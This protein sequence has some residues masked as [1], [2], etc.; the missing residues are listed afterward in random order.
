MQKFALLIFGLVAVS[1]TAQTA[2]PPTN[3]NPLDISQYKDIADGKA[4]PTPQS[5]AAMQTQAEALVNAGKCQEAIPVL[6]LWATQ[7][8]WL[9]N[10]ITAGLDPFYSASYTNQKNVPSSTLNALAP[11]ETQS[12]QYKMQRNLATVIKAECLVKLARPNEAAAVYARALDLINYSES[13]L[14]NRATTGLYALI[15]VTPPKF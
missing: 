13:A 7:S 1:A 3:T 10:L 5:V 8:N 2:T 14:W 6:E 4:L 9:S 12:N 15:G 11:Y